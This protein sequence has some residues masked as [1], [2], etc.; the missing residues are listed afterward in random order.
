MM[1][2]GEVIEL[3]T[4]IFEM[5]AKIFGDL[6]AEEESEEATPEENA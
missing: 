6:F 4:K 3:L 5:L 2:L 1:T